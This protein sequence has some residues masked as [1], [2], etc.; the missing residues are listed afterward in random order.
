MIWRSE[1]LQPIGLVAMANPLH[2]LSGRWTMS[3][4]VWIVL[5][6]LAGFIASHIVNRHGEGIVLDIL[7]GI[8]GAIVGGWLFH[9]L[10]YAGVSGLNLHSLLVAASGAVVV[11]FVYHVIRGA[12]FRRRFF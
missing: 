12:A 7:L 3:L 6:L 11:L 1:L 8:V 10:G 4:F 2:E 9:M 5:G